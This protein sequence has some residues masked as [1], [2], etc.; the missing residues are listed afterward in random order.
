MPESTLPGAVFWD[1]DGTLLD[2]EPLWEGVLAD[3]AARVGAVMTPALR[4]STMGNSS[5]DA[6][7]KVYDAALVPDHGR[8]YETDEAWMVERVLER[9]AGELPWRPGATEALDLVQDA[10]IPM[11]LVTN[12]MR[13]VTE[14]M[15]DTIGR[16]RF[17]ATVCGDEVEAGKPAPHIYRRAAELVS[18]PVNDCLAVED[19]P[20]GSAA[21]FAAGVPA[22]VIPSAIPVP[23]RPTFTFR[24]SLVGLTLSDLG[25]AMRPAAG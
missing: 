3:F 17:V 15:L 14:V 21:T 5:G 8:D 6:M 4:K 23:P 7:T 10:G 9:F 24:E 12:T 11:E 1:M 13:E 16:H 25:D 20:A 22:I 2:T 18:L 19:S